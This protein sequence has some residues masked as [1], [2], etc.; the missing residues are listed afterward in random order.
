M[1]KNYD[2]IADEILEAAYDRLAK[3]TD[4]NGFIACVERT[5]STS[6]FARNLNGE[7]SMQVI[8]ESVRRIIED[9]PVATK[10][11][12]VSILCRTLISLVEEEDIDIPEGA[13]VH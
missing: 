10:R 6:A 4:V 2:K 12:Y 9:M 8:G 3:E 5:D 1:S 11:A 7:S 13:T